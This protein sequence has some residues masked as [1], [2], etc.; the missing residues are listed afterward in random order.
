MRGPVA[1]CKT[2]SLLVATACVLVGCAGKNDVSPIDAE[3]QAFEDLR[4]EIR[5]IIVDPPRETEAIALVDALAEDL[6]TLR[7]KILER[8]QRVRQLNANYDTRRADFEA[9]FD[10]ADR[11]IQSNQQRVTMNHRKFLAI[12]TPEEWSA[13]SKA[14]SGAMN[15]AM[16]AIHTT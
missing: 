11:E 8:R 3:R 13:L 4:N 10:Q 2:A 16:R 5:E 6:G 14:R 7:E 15:A 9:F 1:R 12:T